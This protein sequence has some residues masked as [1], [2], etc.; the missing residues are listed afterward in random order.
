M[1]TASI[2]A[3]LAVCFP[4]T[5]QALEPRPDLAGPSNWSRAPGRPGPDRRGW[6]GR[7]FGAQLPSSSVA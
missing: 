4:V 7:K 5:A 2:A 3:P 6:N 1:S